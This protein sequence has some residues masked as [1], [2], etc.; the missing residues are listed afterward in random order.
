MPQ[1]L[2]KRVRDLLYSSRQPQE[3]GITVVSISQLGTELRELRSLA[4]GCTGGPG[5]VGT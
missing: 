1:E 2:C 3:L 5:R 4:Q